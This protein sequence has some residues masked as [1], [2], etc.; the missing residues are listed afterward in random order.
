[1]IYFKKE[2]NVKLRLFFN[3]IETRVRV[4]K[5][6]HL[7]LKPPLFK[8]SLLHLK[9]LVYNMCHLSSKSVS[10]HRYYKIS[11]VTLRE[12]ANKGLFFGLRKASW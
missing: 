1:M 3:T 5:F 11:R 8:P 6:L 10:M 9:N 4:L 12:S 7:V 2:K